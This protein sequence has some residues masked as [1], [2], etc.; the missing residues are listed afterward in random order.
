[1]LVLIAEGPGS[2]TIA[3][4]RDLPR[5]FFDELRRNSPQ[6]TDTHA[7]FPGNVACAFQ[8][9]LQSQRHADLARHQLQR[10]ELLLLLVVLPLKKR[11][12]EPRQRLGP[13]ARDP[14]PQTI[15][16]SS[17]AGT[18]NPAHEDRGA[19]LVPGNPI[20]LNAALY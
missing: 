5:N 6:A 1:M 2:A 7:I 20:K 16:G 12:S 3:E 15:P 18:A 19:G 4:P 17:H 11:P 14:L 13:L 9:P 8:P 10:G